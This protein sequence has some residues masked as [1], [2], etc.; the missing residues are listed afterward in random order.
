MGDLS[1]N[2][3]YGLNASAE[4]F[5]EEAYRYL[6]ITDIADD[7]HL[8]DDDPTSVSRQ[9][10]KDYALE[11][12]DLVFA[13][14]G[15]TVGKSF[16]YR[17]Y[18]PEMAY[19]GYLIRFQLDTSRVLPEFVFYYTQT[20]NYDRWVT[21]ITRQGAQENINTG[22]YSS[23]LLPVPSK[24]EQQEI[25]NVIETAEERVK[26]EREAKQQLRQLKSGLLQDLLTGRRRLKTDR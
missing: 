20:D 15:A 22:E 3:S 12:G 1:E 21:R 23:I 26:E 17:D 13:R 6:R 4:E 19:A 14:T 8:K 18:H 10:G 2:S 11:P 9:K 24:E 16:L 7:G 5:D 25:V